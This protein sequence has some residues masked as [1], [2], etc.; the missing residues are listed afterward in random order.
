MKIC[1]HFFLSPYQRKHMRFDSIHQAK[2]YLWDY[3]Y[4]NGNLGPYDPDNPVGMSIYPQC[5]Q[6]C[7]TECWHDYPMFQ[8]VVGP[9]GGINRRKV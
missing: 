5:G 1:A 8:F 9:R 3:L 4:P 6:C 7:D 2:K